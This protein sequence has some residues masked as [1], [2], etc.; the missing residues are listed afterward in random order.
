MVQSRIPI[1]RDITMSFEKNSRVSL[2]PLPLV[3]PWHAAAGHP[4]HVSVPA[5]VHLCRVKKQTYKDNGGG[6]TGIGAPHS[7]R[8]RHHARNFTLASPR[9]R[10]AQW[11]VFLGRP[12]PRRWRAEVTCQRGPTLRLG[13]LCIFGRTSLCSQVCVRVAQR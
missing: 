6:F 10:R 5:G 2:S 3:L 1:L 8:R 9:D 4:A 7:S 12:H 13:G 11:G